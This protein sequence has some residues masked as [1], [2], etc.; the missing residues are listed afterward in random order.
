MVYS[1]DE[2]VL[3]YQPYV[4][5]H[6]VAS[7]EAYHVDAAADINRDIEN[8]WLPAQN[9]FFDPRRA[10][11]AVGEMARFFDPELLNPVQWMKSSVFKV[12]SA[13][14]LPSLAA[15]VGGEG[16]IAMIAFYD[17]QYSRE[18]QSVF[19]AGVQYR[20]GSEYLTIYAK[21]VAERNRRER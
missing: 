21:T 13:Y 4:F 6:G 2:D 19:T 20:S 17:R 14:I 5:E 12:L 18:M 7:F 3:K 1:T 9:C 10:G 8:L 15:S 16:F 11:Y